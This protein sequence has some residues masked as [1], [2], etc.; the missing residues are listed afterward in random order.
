MGGGGSQSSSTTTGVP[1]WARPYIET[2]AQDAQSL[3]QQGALDNVAGFSDLQLQA[4]QGASDIYNAGTS[5][6][7]AAA[8]ALFGNATQ[9]AGVFGAD[10]YGKTAAE[11]Q[12]MID[13]QVTRALGQQAGQF[14]GSGNLGGARAQAAAGSTA[15]Q[16][17][18][19]MTMNE[20]AAQRQAAMSGAQNLLS[21]SGQQFGQDMAALNALGAA[22]QQQQDQSQ[23]EQDAQYQ[24][25]QRLFG[26]VN[27]GTVGQTS[28]TTQSGGK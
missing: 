3:Y 28:T 21:S 1:S 14:S 6:E 4:Q 10:A 11:L 27:P 8:N 22:G 15:G 9:G 18:T 5:N 25:I 17:A 19:D 26:L 7:A 20:V 24:G 2:A 13:Q 12:P 16:I 23:A